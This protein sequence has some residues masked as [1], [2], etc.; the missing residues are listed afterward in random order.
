MSAF[1]AQLEGRS[2]ARTSTIWALLER[3]APHHLHARGQPATVRPGDGRVLNTMLHAARVSF[4]SRCVS[5]VC[6]YVQLTKG[7][8]VSAE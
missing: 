4:S 8:C 7:N 3:A 2:E 6:R 5:L 1:L